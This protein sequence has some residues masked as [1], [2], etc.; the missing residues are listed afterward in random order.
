VILKIQDDGRGFDART[1]KAGR[2]KH[3]GL[4]LT[5]M[6]ERALSLGGTYTIESVPGFGTTIVVRVPLKTARESKTGRPSATVKKIHDRN[7]VA[8]IAKFRPLSS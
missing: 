7:T 8:E 2:K 5:N 3:H 4:G 1:V 6:R